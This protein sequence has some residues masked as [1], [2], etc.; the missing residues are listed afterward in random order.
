[1]YVTGVSVE[2]QTGE[3]VF[4][5]E[6]YNGLDLCR[7]KLYYGSLCN[8]SPQ[9]NRVQAAQLNSPGRQALNI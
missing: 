2:P 3:K 8:T 7:V 1:M 4:L 9:I 6:H 5:I